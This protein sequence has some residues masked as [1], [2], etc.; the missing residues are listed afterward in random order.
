MRLTFPS[1]RKINKT[2]AVLGVALVIGIIAALATRSYLSQKIEAIESRGKYETVEL[3]V[4]KTFIPKGSIVAVDDLAI[5]KIPVEFAQ[6]GAVTPQDI[7][8]IAGRVTGYDVKKGEMVMLS[9]MLSKRAPTFSARLENGHRAITVMVDEINSISG[10][11]EPGDLID[12]MFTVDQN[13][14]KVI[15]PLLQHVQVMATGK[16]SVDDPKGGEPVQFATV[17]LNTTPDQAKNIIIARE[18]G[19][20]TALLRSPSDKESGSDKSVDL[21]TLFGAKREGQHASHDGGVPVLYGGSASRF[22]PE[23][24]KLG[25]YRG[26]ATRTNPPPP[27]LIAAPPPA[28]VA[29][30]TTAISP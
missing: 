28:A 3:L 25:R 14:R 5:R 17:T 8:S 4:A 7:L 27:P 10:M 24:L 29:V 23:A 20:L 12:L 11:L 26:T 30:A 16:R 18:T 2:W 13:G 6:S 1:I 21:A 15:F 9:Q 22:P 19:K